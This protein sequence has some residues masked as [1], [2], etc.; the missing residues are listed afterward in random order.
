MIILRHHVSYNDYHC[1]G[2]PTTEL[3]HQTSLVESIITNQSVDL[4]NSMTP[5]GQRVHHTDLTELR[6]AVLVCIALAFV[7]FA[8]ATVL[9]VVIAVLVYKRRKS[10]SLERTKQLRR[11]SDDIWSASVIL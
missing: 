10:L 1:A 11:D 3:P 8:V 6:A 5:G 9:S 4:Y 2:V 7:L